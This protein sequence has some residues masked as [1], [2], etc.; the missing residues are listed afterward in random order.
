MTIFFKFLSSHRGE[1]IQVCD[2]QRDGC[3][4]CDDVR[5]PLGIMK[6]LIFSVPRLGKKQNA[7]LFSAIQHTMPPEIGAKWE[8]EV[9]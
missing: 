6:Y 4:D 8:T 2:Y 9:S 7:L 5:F 1:G 3:D